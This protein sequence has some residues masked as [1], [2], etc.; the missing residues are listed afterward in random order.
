MATVQPAPHPARS[1]HPPTGR[2]CPFH[3]EH[4]AS[5]GGWEVQREP[6]KR[7]EEGEGYHWP[8]ETRPLSDARGSHGEGWPRG[9]GDWEDGGRDGLTRQSHS[10]APLDSGSSNITHHKG[11]WERLLELVLFADCVNGSFVLFMW[12]CII[13]MGFIY[14]FFALHDEGEWEKIVTIVMKDEKSTWVFWVLFGGWGIWNK[15]RS[16]T[17]G[18]GKG[19]SPLSLG[20]WYA[21]KCLLAEGWALRKSCGTRPPSQSGCFASSHLPVGWMCLTHPS[22]VPA[23]HHQ[24][25][26]SSFHASLCHSTGQTEMES[27]WLAGLPQ[28]LRVLSHL[29]AGRA[30]WKTKGGMG[31]QSIRQVCIWQTFCGQCSRG[32]SSQQSWSMSCEQAGDG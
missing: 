25:H 31:R 1:L 28:S 22:R 12:L 30:S 8:W 2:R 10:Q 4:P 18:A 21:V 19:D 5:A 11:P 26:P 14:L 24:W 32:K 20:G 29:K 7:Q 23:P 6:R 13:K 16:K 9:A 3:A 27:C 17:F 15:W